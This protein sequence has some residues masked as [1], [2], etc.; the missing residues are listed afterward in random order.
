MSPKQK[1]NVPPSASPITHGIL[2]PDVS[3]SVSAHNTEMDPPAPLRELFTFSPF[4]L[5]CR[6]CGEQHHAKIKLEERSIRD[7]LKK[8]HM[9]SRMTTV[10]TFVG[11]DLLKQV[12]IA[13]ESCSIEPYRSDQKTYSGY[14]CNCGPVFTRKDNALRHCQ[15]SGC[16]ALKLQKVELIKLCCGRYVSQA[17]V[18]FLFAPRITKQF[19]YTEARATLLPFLTKMEI[20]DHTYTHMYTPLITQCGGSAHFVTKIPK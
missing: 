15:K 3:V 5:C 18:D 10:R 12:Q 2:R 1:A 9:D 16:D 6:Q 7:H 13:K 8:H 11:M 19:N 17:Q 4:G 20:Q 14:S